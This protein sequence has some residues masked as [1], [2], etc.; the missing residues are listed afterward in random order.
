MPDAR[1]Q[2]ADDEGCARRAGIIYAVARRKTTLY[3]LYVLFFHGGKRV[4]FSPSSVAAPMLDAM[5]TFRVEA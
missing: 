5:S 2:S 4:A 1:C 3:L